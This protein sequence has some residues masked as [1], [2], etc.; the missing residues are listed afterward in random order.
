MPFRS[1]RRQ[2]EAPPPESSYEPSARNSPDLPLDGSAANFKEKEGMG[3]AFDLPGD[4]TLVID[5]ITDEVERRKEPTKY[6]FVPCL[7]FCCC[8][9]HD[10]R[11]GVML[12]AVISTV[13]SG[14]LVSMEVKILA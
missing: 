2:A 6:E 1:L 4:D 7:T 5:D 10:H 8:C 12:Y 14:L 9:C 3:S 11:K 13:I